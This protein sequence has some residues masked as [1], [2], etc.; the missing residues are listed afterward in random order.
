MTSHRRTLA[1]LATGLLAV[2]TAL[3][4]AAA[5]GSG[6]PERDE[7]LRCACIEGRLDRVQRELRT[8]YDAKRGRRLKE[9]QR[10]LE[11]QR[12]TECR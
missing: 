11:D 6:V 12:K 9:R 3:P 10:V 7:R 8:G 5:S 1:A 4:F 2:L